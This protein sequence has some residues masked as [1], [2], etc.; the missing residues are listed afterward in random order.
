[1]AEHRVRQCVRRCPSLLA[2]EPQG[3]IVKVLAFQH[4]LNADKAQVWYKAHL[5]HFLVWQVHDR[6]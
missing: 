3:L 1:M 4:I 2:Q 6:L 5:N